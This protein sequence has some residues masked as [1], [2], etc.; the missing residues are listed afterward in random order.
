[1][2]AKEEEHNGDDHPEYHRHDQNCR[3]ND[4]IAQNCPE[5]ERPRLANPP[6]DRSQQPLARE[7]T[8]VSDAPRHGER[9]R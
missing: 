9:R 7:E 4:R 8:R 1:M 5:R 2:V 3:G 6:R